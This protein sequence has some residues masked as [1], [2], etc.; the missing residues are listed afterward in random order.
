MNQDNPEVSLTEIGTVVMLSA[1]FSIGGGNGE[2]ALIQDQ[3]VNQGVL[4]PA[5]FA[6]AFA[7]GHFVPGPHVNFIA[8]VGYYLAG[9]PGAITAVISICVPTSL[10]AAFASHWFNR[11]SGFIYR[12]T[13]A[14]TFVIGG[15]MITAAI[16]LGLPMQIPPLGIL[17]AGTV[18][19]VLCFRSVDPIIIILA[20]GALGAMTR[21]LGQ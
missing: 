2:V 3:W 8:G 19:L 13:L 14:G 15:M 11:L 12:V 20:S 18:C 7:I 1:V 21:W 17:L 16:N 6:W 4:A 10:S 9:I 5:L